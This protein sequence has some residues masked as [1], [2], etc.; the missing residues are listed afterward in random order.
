LP[1]LYNQIRNLDASQT[2]TLIL[3]QM[4][5]CKHDYQ[6]GHLLSYLQHKDDYLLKQENV[7]IAIT[8]RSSFCLQDNMLFTGH[9][10]FFNTINVEVT[11]FF[12]TTCLEISFLK[13]SIYVIYVNVAVIPSE[14]LI[15]TSML[16]LGKSSIKFDP[17]TLHVSP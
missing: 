8:I 3:Q 17:I 11:L 13:T 10:G 12:N 5:T 16:M 7:I 1:V 15:L 6:K 4:T 14:N 9:F 2:F